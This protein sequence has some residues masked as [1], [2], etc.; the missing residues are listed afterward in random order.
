[1]HEDLRSQAR[2]AIVGHRRRVAK[3]RSLFRETRKAVTLFTV[4]ADTVWCRYDS[5]APIKREESNCKHRTFFQDL[6]NTT[7]ATF[8]PWRRLRRNVCS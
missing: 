6:N 1:M 3:R 4:S 5:C 2:F 7:T 8:R